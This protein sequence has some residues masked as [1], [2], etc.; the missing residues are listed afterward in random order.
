MLECGLDLQKR[1][2]EYLLARGTG[3]L[4]ERATREPHGICMEEAQDLSPTQHENFQVSDELHW[5]V[6]RVRCAFE[7]RQSLLHLSGD[8]TVDGM[9]A[10]QWFMREHSHIPPNQHTRRDCTL[11]ARKCIEWPCPRSSLRERSTFIH[12]SALS[13]AFLHEK[14]GYDRRPLLR[15]GVRASS[16]KLISLCC[17]SS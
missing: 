2:T 10:L 13:G 15:G 14:S 6:Y 5:T 17:Y 1:F 9:A 11:L 3:Y 16:S 7:K 8:E 4:H 12:S